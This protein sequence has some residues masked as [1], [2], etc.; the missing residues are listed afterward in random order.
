M[1]VTAKVKLTGKT[2]FTVKDKDTG[3]ETVEQVGLGFAADYDD[4]R[5]KEWSKYT[6]TLSVTMTVLPEVAERFT[7]GAPYTLTFTPSE[8]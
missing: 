5:N 1:S 8:D 3:E 7:A 6:P 2:P 4:G